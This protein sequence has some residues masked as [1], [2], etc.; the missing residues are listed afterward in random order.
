MRTL[1][2]SF[3]C[4]GAASSCLEPMDDPTTVHDLRVLGMSFTPPEVL[5]PQC[6]PSLLVGLAGAADGGL[7]S[8]DPKLQLKLLIYLSIPLEFRALIA[9]PAGQGR[10]LD[11]R[12]LGCASTAD[13]DCNTENQYVELVT[14]TTQGGELRFEKLVPGTQEVHDSQTDAGTPLLFEV[15]NLDSFKGLGG[16]RVP[17]VLDLKA[18]DTGEHIYAQ[19]LAVYSCQFFP[20][21]TTNQLP[22]LP[23]MLWN[24]ESWAEDEVKQAQGAAEVTIEP[25]DF[26]ALQ[27]PYIVP[28]IMLQPVSLVESWKVNSM[29]TLGT[30]G[31]Y[32]LGGTDFSGMAERYKNTWKPDPAAAEQDVTMYFVVRDGRGG[33]SWLV[34][35]AH[36]AP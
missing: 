14:G 21:Q 4:L 7:V 13:R 1:A 17:M 36:W 23:G 29:T 5:V 27:E 20:Q 8:V 11:Y 25:V 12:L 31:T 10:E 24:G 3:L 34:R 6:D 28:S 19:K 18:R 2:L 32:E 15:L 9:D 26:S 33:E 35:H 30:F 16:I 22:V